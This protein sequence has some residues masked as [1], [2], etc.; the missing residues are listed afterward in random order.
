MVG[1]EID[2][3]LG[4][5]HLEDG[6]AVEAGQERPDSC[7]FST[8][9]SKQMKASVLLEIWSVENWWLCSVPFSISITSQLDG[10]LWLLQLR[11]GH[12]DSHLC[13]GSEMEAI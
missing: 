8:S 3:E 7:L 9:P 12:T 4:N 10:L 1:G 5:M 2:F 13:D 6:L 11:E